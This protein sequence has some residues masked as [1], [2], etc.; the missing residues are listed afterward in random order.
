MSVCVSILT[1]GHR[2]N[3]VLYD[4][5]H[6]S[7]EVI[8]HIQAPDQNQDNTPGFVLGWISCFSVAGMHVPTQSQSRSYAGHRAFRLDTSWLPHGPIRQAL[9]R[10]SEI[11]VSQC[12]VLDVRWNLS[13]PAYLQIHTSWAD[14]AT[15]HGRL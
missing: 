12:V 1:D 14:E 10:R 9:Q 3:F 8:V 4:G 5:T 6:T 2:P 13:K 15:A 7:S 11:P